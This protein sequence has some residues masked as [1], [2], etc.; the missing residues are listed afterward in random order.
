MVGWLDEQW[1]YLP[2]LLIFT[3]RGRPSGIVQ[4]RLFWATEW[5][6]RVGFGC[7]SL[8]IQMNIISV[9]FSSCL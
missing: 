9:A 4:N 1:V 6:M 3:L 8:H 5:G 2:G 7:F